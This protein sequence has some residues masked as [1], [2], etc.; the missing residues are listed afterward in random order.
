MTKTVKQNQIIRNMVEKGYTNTQIVNALGVSRQ[1]V[2]SARYHVNRKRGIAGLPL[3]RNADAKAKNTGI[4]S[5]SKPVGRPSYIP[6]EFDL[7]DRTEKKKANNRRKGQLKRWARERQDREARE[8]MEGKLRSLGAWKQMGMSTGNTSL[9]ETIV[10][11]QPKHRSLWQR[12]KG[13][14][15]GA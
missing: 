1:A 5:V 12:I 11:L 8:A 2:H 7:I 13:F 9:L 14:F 3:V 15:V 6:P 10:T 4:A